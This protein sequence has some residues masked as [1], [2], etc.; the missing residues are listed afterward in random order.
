LQRFANAWI[1][2]SCGL[3][4]SLDDQVLNKKYKESLKKYWE[5][6][7]LSGIFADITN[8]LENPRGPARL[9]HRLT[10][11]TPQRAETQLHRDGAPPHRSAK[12]KVK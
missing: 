7:S 10:G 12:D 6:D 8:E 2:V 3:A 11:A 1:S 9:G 5:L 4:L